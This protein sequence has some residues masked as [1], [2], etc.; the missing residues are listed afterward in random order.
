VLRPLSTLLVLLDVKGAHDIGLDFSLSQRSRQQRSTARA[1]CSALFA[2]NMFLSLEMTLGQVSL[3]HRP[4][5][6]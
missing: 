6:C 2:A 3:P 5:P 1:V 4:R